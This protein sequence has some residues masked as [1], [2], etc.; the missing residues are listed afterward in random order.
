MLRSMTGYGEGSERT[1]AFELSVEVKCVNN[2]FLKITSK[3]PEEVSYLQNEIEPP[4]REALR[5]GSVYVTIQFEPASN[6]ELYHVDEPLLLKYAS[7]VQRLQ[8]DL[9][10]KEPVRVTDLLLL[11]GVINTESRAELSREQVLPVALK[12]LGTALEQV[13]KMRR[14]EGSVLEKEFRERTEILAATIE[15]I[16]TMYPKALEQNYRRLTER[17]NRLLKDSETSLSEDDLHREIAVLGERADISE[18]LSRME[19]HTCQFHDSLETPDPVGRKL[20]FI[21]QEMFRE[22]N[23]MGSKSVDSALNRL[24]VDL[25]AEVTRLKEQVLNVE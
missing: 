3:V 13:V 19:S 4:I 21:V 5:R 20:E 6:A 11:P 14:V 25:K 16:R 9:A 10:S 22:C 15:Q 1:E 24:V 7:T 12:A 8:K 18:E 23:T 17:I 2:K